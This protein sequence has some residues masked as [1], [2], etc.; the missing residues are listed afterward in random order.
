M[1]QAGY[2]EREGGKQSAVKVT[3]VQEN[4]LY[5]SRGHRQ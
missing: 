4:G 5:H 3:A 1:P 2:P